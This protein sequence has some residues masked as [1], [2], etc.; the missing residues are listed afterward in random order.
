MRQLLR[1]QL[2]R[3]AEAAGLI[4]DLAHGGDGKGDALAE[5][6][7]RIHQAFRRSAAQARKA[8]LI[9][10]GLLAALVLGRQGMGA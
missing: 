6:I 2:H 4:K 3:Q 9:E 5:A 10:I 7:D 8:D 1:M